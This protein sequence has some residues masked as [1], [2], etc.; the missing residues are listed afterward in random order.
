[1]CSGCSVNL[2]VLYDQAVC[3]GVRVSV[4]LT[5]SALFAGVLSNICAYIYTCIYIRAHIY[6][7][8]YTCIYIL[9]YIRCIYIR[10]HIYGAYI[11]CIYMRAHIYGAYKRFWPTPNVKRGGCSRE[12]IA[13]GR[14][15]ALFMYSTGT[16][17][18]ATY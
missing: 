1:M 17:K 5:S 2:F 18:N 14:Q 8:I 15:F 6:V 9:A 13:L 4:R 7:H 3:E 16:Q 10:A 12:G 11:Q